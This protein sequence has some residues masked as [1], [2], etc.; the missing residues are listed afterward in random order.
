MLRIL[1]LQLLSNYGIDTRVELHEILLITNI[2]NRETRIILKKIYY[3][4]MWI[5]ESLL[6]CELP[7]LGF[8]LKLWRVIFEFAFEH[9]LILIYFDMVEKLVWYV[10]ETIVF[11]ANV[12]CDT[13][14]VTILVWAHD[15]ARWLHYSTQLFLKLIDHWILLLLHLWVIWHIWLFNL[16]F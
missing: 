6:N 1:I 8:Y 9:P 3:M 15:S 16:W 11:E 7:N 10:D 4:W 13:Y 14:I 2:K 5:K 12:G